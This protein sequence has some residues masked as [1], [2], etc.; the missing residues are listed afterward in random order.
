MLFHTHEFLALLIITLVIFNA[1][2][3]V[4]RQAVLLAASM[5]FYAYAGVGMLALFVAVA[6]F[7][8]V[9]LRRIEAGDRRWVL[10][11]VTGLVINL[12]AFKYSGFLPVGI[13]FY[14]FQ[15]I[16]V[17]IDASRGQQV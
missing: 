5:L 11:G 10:I 1:V 4:R 16:A 12:V 8:Y 15:L 7:A 3:V 13:S 17:L 9:A 14:S 2:P 6:A